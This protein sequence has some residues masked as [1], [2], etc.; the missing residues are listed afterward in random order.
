MKKLYINNFNP[1]GKAYYF[2]ALDENFCFKNKTGK[3]SLDLTEEECKTFFKTHRILDAPENVYYCRNIYKSLIENGQQE[4]VNVHNYMCPHYLVE[5][6]HHRICIAAKKGLTLKAHLNKNDDVCR[7]CSSFNRLN[8]Q[9]KNRQDM[10]DREITKQTM[11]QKIFGEKTNES[12]HHMALSGLR[13][14]LE[15]W[16]EFKKKCYRKF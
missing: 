11:L 5:D 7:V 8:N 13:N 15:Y 3:C 10:I 14:Q 1:S 6:G 4:P 9:I 16:D 2:N 12:F